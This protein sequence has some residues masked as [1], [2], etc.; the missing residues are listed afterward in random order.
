MS[1]KPNPEFMNASGGIDFERLFNTTAVE[2][3]K[4]EPKPEI[5]KPAEPE[6]PE[7]VT[8]VA[9]VLDDAYATAKI[10]NPTT[11]IGLALQSALK[12]AKPAE[13][14]IATAT[15]DSIISPAEENDAVRLTN[16]ETTLAMSIIENLPVLVTGK[17][18]DPLI[19]WLC[20]VVQDNATVKAFAEKN[21]IE[22]T[23]TEEDGCKIT[24]TD[25]K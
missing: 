21:D 2:V 6:K 9:Q 25:D 5:I 8:S 19:N 22:C 14:T 17:Y 4:K 13:E 12:D 11:A 7:P 23:V 1:T 16:I 15:I 20:H 18:T 3:T 10:D 24:F